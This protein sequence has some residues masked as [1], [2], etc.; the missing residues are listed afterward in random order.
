MIII[1]TQCFPPVPGGIETLVYSLSAA[2][3]AAGEDIRV[4]ADHHSSADREFDARQHF[5]ITRYSGLKPLRR[6]KKAR[7]IFRHNLKQGGG[8]AGLITDS[9][10]SLEHVDKTRFSVVLCL[11]H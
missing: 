5:S 6:R 8:A 1:S 2:L 4:Y 11:A 3:S 10:K 7:D 9:W